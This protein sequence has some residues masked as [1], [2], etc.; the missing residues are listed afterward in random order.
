MGVWKGMI[1]SR[2]ECVVG[3]DLLKRKYLNVFFYNEIGK[4]FI[5]M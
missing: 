5:D 2:E 3:I 4:E 1:W